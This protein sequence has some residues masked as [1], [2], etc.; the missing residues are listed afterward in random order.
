MIK[1]NVL[2]AGDGANGGPFALVETSIS[3]AIT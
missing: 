3:T 1:S 2:V